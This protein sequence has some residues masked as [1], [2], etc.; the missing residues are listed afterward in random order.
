MVMKSKIIKKDKDKLIKFKYKLSKCNNK[1]LA[2]HIYIL[3]NELNCLESGNKYFLY[4]SNINF[5]NAPKEAHDHTLC[6]KKDIKLI[7]RCLYNRD[8]HR[9]TDFFEGIF[10]Y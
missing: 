5:K 1:H 9:Q 10:F 8:I 6:T 3:E 4:S 7:L 2:L